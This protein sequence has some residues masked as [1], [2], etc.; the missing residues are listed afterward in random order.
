MV[1]YDT[2][3]L[4]YSE[5][6]VTA[7][8]QNDMKN[9]YLPLILWFAIAYCMAVPRYT[10]NTGF[11][12]DK[13]WSPAGELSYGDTLYIEHDLLVSGN[14][15]FDSEH[16]TIILNSSLGF[17]PG[18]SLKLGT[19]S[20][21]VFNVSPLALGDDHEVCITS[22]NQDMTV[23]ELNKIRPGQVMIGLNATPVTL[24]RFDYDKNGDGLTLYWITV[25]E[26]DNEYFTISRSD[27]AEIWIE[28][29]TV[30]GS[31]TVTEKR[32]YSYRPFDPKEGYYRLS[33]TD[34]DGTTEQIGLIHVTGLDTRQVG[35]FTID[36]DEQ[37]FDYVIAD[38]TGRRSHASLQ[39][40]VL[41]TNKGKYVKKEYT[42]D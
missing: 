32:E 6:V 7:I 28:I 37:V 24:L 39:I 42:R 30:K 17:V 14:V 23:A 12:D 22:G 36:M 4:L 26:T 2:P 3:F 29:A 15:S 19:G 8:N 1:P 10:Q 40:H 13:E 41:I 34:F 9:I 5:T 33:Q 31:G 20:V 11:L 16:V 18:A 27:D 21:L 35:L 38:C 25:T